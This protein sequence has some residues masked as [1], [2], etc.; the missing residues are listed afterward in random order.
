MVQHI[1][2]CTD[3]GVCTS[4][5]L[6]QLLTFWIGFLQFCTSFYKDCYLLLSLFLCLEY[7]V[8]LC[9][10]CYFEIETATY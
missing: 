8:N 2:M 5:Q 10:R 6:L 3:L 4:Q 7:V 9:L 1:F